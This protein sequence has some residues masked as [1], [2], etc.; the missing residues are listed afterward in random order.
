M[1]SGGLG[2]SGVGS[3]S[4]VSDV[5]GFEVSAVLGCA[6]GPERMAW[7]NDRR[8]WRACGVWENVCEF[9]FCGWCFGKAGAGEEAVTEYVVD[10]H[11]R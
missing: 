9:G 4:E 5:L 1:G 7:D 2:W 11:R 8:R 10:G 6:G 3:W